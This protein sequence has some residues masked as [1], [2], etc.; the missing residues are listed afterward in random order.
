MTKEV[1]FFPL[2]CKRKLQWRFLLLI[3]CMISGKM[4]QMYIF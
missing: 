2:G 3:L 4:K 1:P